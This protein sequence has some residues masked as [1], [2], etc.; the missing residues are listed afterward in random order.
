[1]LVSPVKGVF[2]V[3]VEIIGGSNEKMATPEPTTEFTVTEFEI[4]TPTPSGTKQPTL[5]VDDQA[6]VS[7]NRLLRRVLTVQS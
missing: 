1:M 7:H 2:P 3:P 4:E 5:V 6:V